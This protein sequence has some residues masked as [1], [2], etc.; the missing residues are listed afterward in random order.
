MIPV[1][2]TVPLLTT[3]MYTN[4]GNEFFVG[5]MKNPSIS[6]FTN[7]DS[8]FISTNQTESM[9]PVNVTIRGG[10]TRVLQAAAGVTN[11]LSVPSSET[12]M[13]PQGIHILAGDS[14]M[15]NVFGSNR[16]I[17]S[18]DGFLALPCPQLPVEQYTYYAVSVPPPTSGFTLTESNSAILIVSC[19]NNTQVSF[20]PTQTVTDPHNSAS[21]IS[22]GNNTKVTLEAA[23]PLYIRGRGDLTGT[24]IVSDRPISV[25]SGHECAYSP[26]TQ[27]IQCNHLVEQIPPTVT[28]GRN[29]LTA[30]SPDRRTGDFPKIVASQ[31]DTAVNITCIHQAA[32]VDSHLAPN[33]T[34]TLEGAGNSWNFTT[35][36][37]EYCSIEA[38]KPILVTQFGVGDANIGVN[39]YMTLIPAVSQYRNDIQFS[40]VSMPELNSSHWVNIFVTPT[41]FEPSNITVDGLEGYLEDWVAIYG[42]NGDVCGY[43]KQTNR[44]QLPETH[45]H[46]IK[47]DNPAASL[48]VVVYGS[49][50]DRP[51]E[52]G[53]P[54]GLRLSGKAVICVS[55]VFPLAKLSFLM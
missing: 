52:Y 33:F 23:Q 36:A 48:G 45:S 42:S 25:F 24:S 5:Y 14:N 27:G 18:I 31:E 6:T 17:S 9:V 43:A 22:A 49:V 28:W 37:T 51:R 20:T 53:Y 16:E 26:P 3:A 39:T 15:L 1:N 47:H 2:S 41:Y 55:K 38:D 29:F 44:T 46:L 30:P 19:N 34:I 4:E 7:D 10:R 50:G 8:F 32:L 40:V 12:R 21:N 54:G 35:F 13:P 11:T